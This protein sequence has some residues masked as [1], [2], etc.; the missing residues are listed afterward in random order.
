M[1]AVPLT[2]IVHVPSHH[3][4]ISSGTDRTFIVWDDQNYKLLHQIPT[5]SQML[6]LW[7]SSITKNLYTGGTDGSIYVWNLET[8]C[9]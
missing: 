8:V 7:Y 3:K 4:I 5:Y 1:I 9:N 6:S 2:F